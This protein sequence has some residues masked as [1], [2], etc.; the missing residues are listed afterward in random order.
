MHRSALA[1]QKQQWWNSICMEITVRSSLFFPIL[2]LQQIFR[3]RKILVNFELSV[4]RKQKLL[5]AIYLEYVFAK[6]G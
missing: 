2:Q 4:S 5:A 3:N 6:N 1:L